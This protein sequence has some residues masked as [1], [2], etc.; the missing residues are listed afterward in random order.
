MQVFL[1]PTL[2]S[3]VQAKFAGEDLEVKFEPEAVE[4]EEEEEE[5]L[6]DSEEEDED[7]V[8]AGDIAE[9]F[10]TVLSRVAT[11]DPT[12]KQEKRRFFGTT[13]YFQRNYS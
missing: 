12:L 10:M 8:L 5:E 3:V 11:R 2:T 7:G 1:V 9:E 6:S 4:A 13:C